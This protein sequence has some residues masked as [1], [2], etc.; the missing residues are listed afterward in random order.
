MSKARSRRFHLR[1]FQGH[2][3]TASQHLNSRFVAFSAA[4]RRTSIFAFRKIV[5]EFWRPAPPKRAIRTSIPRIVAF[6]TK[7]AALKAP[8]LVVGVAGSNVP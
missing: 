2:L 3:D 1:W 5:G 6:E 4:V 8:P 7:K